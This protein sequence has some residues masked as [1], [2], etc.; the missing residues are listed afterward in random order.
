MMWQQA[1]LPPATK[2]WPSKGPCSCTSTGIGRPARLG[3]CRLAQMAGMAEKPGLPSTAPG[4]RQCTTTGPRRAMLALQHSSRYRMEEYTSS[5]LLNMQKNIYAYVEKLPTAQQQQQQLQTERQHAGTCRC[6]HSALQ[7]TA[8][9]SS[10]SCHAAY[11][12]IISMS[13]GLCIGQ[14]RRKGKLRSADTG[15]PQAFGQTLAENCYSG[16]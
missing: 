7:W 10:C 5:C 14:T 16:K 4:Q 12:R 15:W 1:I 3:Y 11:M 6:T 2:D 13:C 8:P 9:A